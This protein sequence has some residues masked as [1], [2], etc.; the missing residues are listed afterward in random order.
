MMPSPV[1]ISLTNTLIKTLQQLGGRSSRAEIYDLMAEKMG[2]SM[3]ARYEEN[4]EGNYK[5]EVELNGSRAFLLGCQCMDESLPGLW[6]LTMK[7]HEALPFSDADLIDMGEVFY[8]KTVK[9]VEDDSAD[10]DKPEDPGTT[11]D[12]AQTKTKRTRAKR[13][14]V[15]KKVVKKT[16]TKRKYNRKV[17][18]G[19]AKK[20]KSTFPK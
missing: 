20:V 8:Y 12:G 14:I 3:K 9:K 6:A 11:T 18:T 7:G 13:K 10:E 2:L 5:F 17:P 4:S 1:R 16:G 19:Q 15:K